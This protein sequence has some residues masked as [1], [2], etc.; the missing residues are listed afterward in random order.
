MEADSF[1]RAIGRWGGEGELVMVVE[2]L[3]GPTRRHVWG[4]CI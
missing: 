2:L 3:L 1:F 4:E